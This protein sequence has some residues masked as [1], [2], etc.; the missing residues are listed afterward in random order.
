MPSPWHGRSTLPRPAQQEAKTFGTTLS[1]SQVN[2]AQPSPLLLGFGSCLSSSLWPLALPN[3]SLLTCLFIAPQSSPTPLP[4]LLHKTC[5]GI[6]E[7][8]RETTLVRVLQRNRTNKGCVRACMRACMCVCLEKERF[9][10][11]KWSHDY[12]GWQVENLQG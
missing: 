1:L 5:P 6:K 7:L 4:L 12:G 9:I 3:C 2:P 10:L 8:R 11:K